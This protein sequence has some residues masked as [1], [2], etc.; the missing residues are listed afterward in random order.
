MKTSLAVNDNSI[1]LN[2]F[3][4]DYI[5]NVMMGIAVSLGHSSNAITLD[6]NGTDLSLKTG[7]GDVII[8]KDFAKMLIES[9]IKGILSPLNGVLWLQRI[10]I[11]C[12]E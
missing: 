12:T 10:T 8:L 3:T 9:T 6:I 11:V 7:K 4:Q 2:D 1:P 5:G